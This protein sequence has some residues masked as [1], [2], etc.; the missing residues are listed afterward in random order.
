VPWV[1]HQ[2]PLIEAELSNPGGKDVHGTNDKKRKRPTDS[3]SSTP[4]S[5]EAN[6]PHKRPKPNGLW[7]SARIAALESRKKREG[8]ENDKEVTETAVRRGQ[9]GY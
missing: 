1:K 3:N 9:E 8:D 2:I 6:R 5:T 4:F 7:Q